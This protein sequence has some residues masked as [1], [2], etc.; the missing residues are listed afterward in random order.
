MNLAV[1]VPRVAP[2]ETSGCGRELVKGREGERQAS[3]SYCH[4]SSS[5]S[6]LL[7]TRNLLGPTAPVPIAGAQNAPCPG[8]A[9]ESRSRTTPGFW[10]VVVH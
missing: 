8:H 6:S 5:V 3:P 2:D 1:L 10:K 4:P 7:R 9:G